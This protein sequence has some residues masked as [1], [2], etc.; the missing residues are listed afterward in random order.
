MA[1]AQGNS[2]YRQRGNKGRS[3][4]HIISECSKFALKE[5]RNMREWVGRV[6]HWDI[7]KRINV[8][9]ADQWYKHRSGFHLE[10]ET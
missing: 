1:K 5:Y 3:A 9:Y 4:N 2:K 10:N 8:E 6:I 7:Q